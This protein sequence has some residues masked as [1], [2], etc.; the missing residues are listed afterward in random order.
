MRD[1]WCSAYCQRFG[2]RTGGILICSIGRWGA[3]I[4][5]ETEVP[6]VDPGSLHQHTSWVHFDD[7][8]AKTLFWFFTRTLLKRVNARA[9]FDVELA[10]SVKSYWE[11]VR[12]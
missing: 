8:P 1:V 10:R 7:H 9:L 6:G 4:V 11:Q 2:H 3:P 12:G 5:V